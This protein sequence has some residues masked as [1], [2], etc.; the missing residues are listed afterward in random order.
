MDNL[1]IFKQGRGKPREIPK[2]LC[3]LNSTYI[4]KNMYSIGNKGNST[5]N[6]SI[7]KRLYQIRSRADYYS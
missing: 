7:H 2:I 6:K 4:L 1:G 5:Q 3:T